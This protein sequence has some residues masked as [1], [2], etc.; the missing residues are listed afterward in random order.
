MSIGK[1]C[2][3]PRTLLDIIMT[4]I[5]LVSVAVCVCLIGKFAGL[6]VPY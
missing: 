5:L 4:V 1:G 2:G 6:P 3:P